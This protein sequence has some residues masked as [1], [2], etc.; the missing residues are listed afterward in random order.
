MAYKLPLVVTPKLSLAHIVQ[1]VPDLP[2]TVCHVPPEGDNSIPLTFNPELLAFHPPTV[3]VF[4][5]EPLSVT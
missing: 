5:D 4:I 3:P 1:S 2:L